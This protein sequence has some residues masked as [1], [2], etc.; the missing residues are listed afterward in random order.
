MHFSRRE[1]LK[2][3]VLSAASLSLGLTGCDDDDDDKKEA[4]PDPGELEIRDG[5][6]YFA[7]GLASGDPKPDS[8]VLW[9]RLAPEQADSGWVMRVQVAG[10]E[11]FNNLLVDHPLPAPEAAHDYC[12][13]VKITELT[14]ATRYYYRF[15]GVDGLVAHAS[16][17]GRTRTAPA[18]DADTPV[19]FAV[20]SC[21]DYIGRY[22]NTLAWLNAQAGEPDFIAHVGDYI[23]ETTGDPSYQKADAAARVVEFSQ[24]GD[25]L[26]VGEGDSAYLAAQSLSNYRDIYQL[27]RTDS[28]LQTLHARFP[29][30]AIWDDHEYSDDCFGATA[31][32]FSGKRR[33]VN[34]E[35]R[36]NAEQVFFEYMPVDD[37][38]STTPD[39]LFPEREALHPNTRLYR[40]LRFGR[41]LHLLLTDSRSFRPDHLIPED[42]FPG[43]VVMDKQALIT[44]FEAMQPGMGQAMYEAQK[45]A[46]GPY[47]DMQDPAWGQYLP[48]LLVI[49][50]QAYEMEG[51]DQ[52]VLQGKAYAD[53]SG[54]LNVMVFNQLAGQ[55]NQA[56]QAG[57]LLGDPIPLIDEATAAGLDSGLAYLHFGKQGFFSEYG[58]R[59][60]VVQPSFDLYAAYLYFSTL[61]QGGSPENLLGGEQQTWLETQ[62][63]TSDATFL[64][65]ASSISTASLIL[66]LSQL[67]EMVPAQYRAAFYLNVDQWDGFP[68]LRKRLLEILRMRGNAFLVA[69]DIHAALVSDH[70]GVV[71]FT[72]PAVSSETFYEFV[73]RAVGALSAEF[74]PEQRE[75][76]QALLAGNL[77]PLLQQAFPALKYANTGQQGY[78]MLEVNGQ[79]VSAEY[80]L[81]DRELVGEDYYPDPATLAERVSRRR[82]VFRDGQLGM[83]G[84]N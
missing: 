1:F 83:E 21:Q 15:L 52:E 2:L 51:A 27:L 24:P 38:N 6:S 77:D 84:M 44:T 32:Y 30:V 49:L 33:E 42:A 50:T 76:I 11:N 62:I 82:F 66:D 60:A 47:V 43:K 61:Q 57:V 71:D 23:Y 72:G 12:V 10:D 25:A 14:P 8:V 34:P 78:V 69:G 4:N 59:Y 58:S 64:A 29:M 28:A 70:G 26:A 40:D 45:A 3:T 73:Q 79:E 5:A 18:P 31:T 13:K 80:Y 75:G 41:H 53:L 20:L 39:A 67:G 68:N 35:R 46:F 63:A 65:V 16:R 81:F 22:F 36:R 54:K 56:L 7:W 19:R 9:T 17:I 37:E 48:A 74:D 55:Y